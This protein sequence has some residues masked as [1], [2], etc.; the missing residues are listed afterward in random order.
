DHQARLGTPR[1]A[2]QAAGRVPARVH[3]HLGRAAARIGAV[4]HRA[5]GGRLHVPP[6]AVD[7]AGVRARDP[8]AQV[9]DGG[10]RARPQRDL[11]HRAAAGAGGRGGDRRAH[12]Q[13]LHVHR[14]QHGPRATRADARG[15]HRGGG[16]GGRR[17]HRTRRAC[18]T[19]LPSEHRAR[20]ARRRTPRDPDRLADRGPGRDRARPSAEGGVPPLHDGAPLRRAAP[21]GPAAPRH[22]GVPR[23]AGDGRAQ[24]GDPR[25]PAHV[26]RGAPGGDRDRAPPRAQAM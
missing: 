18:L 8:S 22:H 7:G 25:P 5:P 10:G 4:R 6:R 19:H 21:R 12:R 23:P 17:R 1:V 14:L 20:A 2:G 13:L 16:G 11:P 24:R 3:Q 9:P 26:G 15:G